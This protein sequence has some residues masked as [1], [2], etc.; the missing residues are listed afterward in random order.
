MAACCSIPARRELLPADVGTAAA[1]KPE[2]VVPREYIF[3]V[4]VS[5]SMHGF[6]WRP[7]RS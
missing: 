5:G 2:A 6:P 7:P 4:D 1:V 3:I